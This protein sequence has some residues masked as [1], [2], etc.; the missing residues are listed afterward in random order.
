MD[1]RTGQLVPD[2]APRIHRSVIKSCAKWNYELAQKIIDGK[3]ISV[4][5]LED[6]MIPSDGHDFLDLAQD[7]LK[8][9]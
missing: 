7:V 5:Q 3:L 2:H 9:H 1:A 6:D 8:L 4:D